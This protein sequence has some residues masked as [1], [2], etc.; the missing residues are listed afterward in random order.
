MRF[1]FCMTKAIDKPSVH[2]IVTVFPRQQ[3]LLE[4]TLM[5]RV[6]LS[7]VLLFFYISFIDGEHHSLF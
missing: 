5:L 6:Y 4:R 2:V 7:T 1:A 3:W